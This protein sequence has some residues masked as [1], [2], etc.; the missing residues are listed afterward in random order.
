M[1]KDTTKSTINELVNVIDEVTF[2]KIINVANIDHYVKKLTAYKFLQLCIIVQLNEMESL[3]RFSKHLKDKEELQTFIEFDAISTSQLSRKQC[4]LSSRLFE[5]IFKHLVFKVQAQ[6]KSDPIIRDIGKLQVIDSSTMSMSL[7]QYPWA[8]FRKTKAGV[9]LHLRV[10]VTRDLTIPDKA[11]ILPAKHADRSQM[12]EL[13]S[14]LM[15]FNCLTAATMT[16]NNL[17]NFVI[18]VFRSSRV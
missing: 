15:R 13:K 12:N 4:N 6:M 14:M 9:R 7:S 2:Y 3:T 17:K 18:M 11:V 1:D 16:I 5:K 10:V 8:T